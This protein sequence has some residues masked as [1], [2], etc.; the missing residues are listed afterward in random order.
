M[1]NINALIN[2][3]SLLHETCVNNSII[4]AKD[5]IAKGIDVNLKDEFKGASALHYCAVY[6]YFEIAKLILENGGDI[7]ISDRYGNQPL[8][9]ATFEVKGNPDRLPLVELFLKYGADKKIRSH[10]I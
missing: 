2:G 1:E 3:R 5:L 9:T 8:W 6:N 10:A 7:N 4:E